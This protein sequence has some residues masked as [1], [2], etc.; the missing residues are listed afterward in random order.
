MNSIVSIGNA[1][2]ISPFMTSECDKVNTVGLK[3][4]LEPDWHL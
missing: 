1:K 3:A 2:K 4:I